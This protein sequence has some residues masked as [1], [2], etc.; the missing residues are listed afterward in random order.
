MSRLDPALAATRLAVRRVLA[1]GT[2]GDVAVVACS[3][4]ADSTALVAATVFEAAKV[5][6]RVIGATVDHGLQSGSAAQASATVELMARLGVDETL[7]ATVQVD[8][9]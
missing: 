9:R 4:G 1:N 3:G 2:P 8:A 5:G 7:T 6:V